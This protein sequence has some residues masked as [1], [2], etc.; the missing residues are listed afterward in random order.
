MCPPKGLT[1]LGS[2]T[3]SLSDIPSTIPPAELSQSI[4]AH[5]AALLHPF[6]L[7][8]SICLYIYIKNLAAAKDSTYHTDLAEHNQLF[9]ACLFHDIGTRRRTTGRSN[10]KS[11]V[12]MP[13]S[14]ICPTLA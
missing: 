13:P 6:T 4:Y 5:A 10:S 3:T 12:S 9:V 8:H 2:S 14:C 1:S 7:N 11:K